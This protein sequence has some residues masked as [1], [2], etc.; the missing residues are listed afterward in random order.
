MWKI[1]SQ[2]FQKWDYVMYKMWQNK[3]YLELL[4]YRNPKEDYEVLTSLYE[5]TSSQKKQC[6][7]FVSQI[8][9]IC[10]SLDMHHILL[11]K[12]LCKGYTL[13]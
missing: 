7:I 9:L 3:I 13:T 10:H 2:I 4:Q 5:I 1:W 8:I 11:E 6:S 12:K